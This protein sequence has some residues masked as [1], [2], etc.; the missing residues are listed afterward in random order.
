MA[1]RTNRFYNK[2]KQYLKELQRSPEPR[3]KRWLVVSSGV[4]MLF[5]LGLWML[6]LNLSLP[7]LPTANPNT[8]SSAPAPTTSQNQNPSFFETFGRGL[9]ITA[10]NIGQK[11]SGLIGWIGDLTNNLKDQLQK[12]NQFSVQAPPNDFVPNN[13]ETI[14]TTTLP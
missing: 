14:P 2:S 1:D 3:K 10:D 8:T 11:L 7:T 4:A 12:T 13:L 5:V 6:Y 9:Q